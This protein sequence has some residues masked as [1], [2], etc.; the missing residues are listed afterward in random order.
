MVQQIRNK[1]KWAYTKYNIPVGRQNHF[2][3]TDTHSTYL[4]SLSW[5]HVT[6]L[7]ATMANGFPVMKWEASWDRTL[8][9]WHRVSGI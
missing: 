2:A 7:L 3:Y 5:G 1:N 9:M 6:S 8:V 4:V